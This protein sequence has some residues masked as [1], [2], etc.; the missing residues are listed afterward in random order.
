MGTPLRVLIVAASDDRA[1][2]ILDELRRGGYEPQALRVDLRSAFR[3][4]IAREKWDVVVSE[5]DVPRLDGLSALALVQQSTQRIPFILVSEPLGHESVVAIMKAGATDCVTR[6]GLRRLTPVVSRELREAAKTR[7]TRHH[8]SALQ[9][10]IERVRRALSAAFAGTWDWDL[11]RDKL[12]FSDDI[13]SVLGR[14]P[15]TS[16]RDL[17]DLVE[18]SDRLRVGETLDEALRTGNGYEI[19]YRIRSADEEVRW[20][21]MTGQVS[22]SERGKPIRLTGLITDVTDR[23]APEPVHPGS[24][25]VYEPLYLDAPVALF[26]LDLDG[27]I[28]RANLRAAELLGSTVEELRGRHVL[29]FHPEGTPSRE[30]V[31]RL[32]QRCLAGHTAHDDDVEF[33]SS[34]GPGWIGSLTLSP[35]LDD[36][37]QVTACRV[38]LV[39]VTEQRRGEELLQLAERA[40]EG[41][42]DPIAVCGPDFTFR[43]V[44]AALAEA[45]GEPAEGIVGRRLDDLFGDEYQHLGVHLE[46]CLEGVD[47]RF[48][49]WLTFRALGRRYLAAS[50]TPLRSAAD[51]I[52]G[53]ILV[54]R[55]ITERHQ[56]E[57]DREELEGQLRQAHKME[58]L[59]TLAGG[60]AHDFNNLLLAILGYAEITRDDLPEDSP[61]RGHLNRIMTAGQRAQSLVKQIVAFGRQSERELALVEVQKTVL[62]G[63]S[64][65]RASLP[66]TIE[67]R[68]SMDPTSCLVLADAAQLQQVILNLAAN[69]GHAMRESGGVLTVA[70]E[71]VELG[72]EAAGALGGATPGGYVKIV[73]R[74]TGHGIAPDA[75][76]RIYD[77]FYTTKAPGEGTG[78][79]LSVVH[80]IVLSHGGALDVVSHPGRGTTFSVYLPRSEMERRTT[81]EGGVALSSGS[82]RVL[83]VDDEG[84]VAD[85]GREVLSRLGYDVEVH[86]SPQTALAA[87]QAEPYGFDVIVTDQTM[88]YLTG[89]EFAREVRRFRGDIPI[90]LT[91]GYSE[92]VTTESLLRQNIAAL[93]MK[94]YGGSEL[95][96][97]VRDALA[98]VKTSKV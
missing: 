36:R 82:E 48:E 74:D 16:R 41:S 7:S 26:S 32:L 95:N 80:G 72:P 46:R 13:E 88:P 97:A 37:G 55:D 40:V 44:N 49:V 67:I 20:M 35:V 45:A 19:S 39:D 64:F 63:M 68:E 27:L 17:F 98:E 91:T 4:A 83:F 24:E 43:R 8:E 1:R 51:H 23:I 34:G 10:K 57:Q 2:P 56:A 14:D 15:P 33:A 77:P 30:R 18:E 47:V 31:R 84:Y 50:L 69:A 5:Y 90:V 3:T 73:V 12:S 29:E 52:E 60:I 76:N 78:L 79:G 25:E 92:A 38:L 65:L 28:E 6:Q 61:L 59:G 81:P 85:L 93:V 54:L 62:E 9:P 94:P 86:T 70:V 87:F 21:R 42:P 58:A 53:A 71:G 89:L 11:L 75:L 96:R 22:G 66:S